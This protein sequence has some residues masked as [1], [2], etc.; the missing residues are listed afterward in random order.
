MEKEY[1]QDILYK[2][3]SKKSLKNKNK[4]GKGE[5]RSIET[6]QEHRKNV[7]SSKIKDELEL[8]E[9]RKGKASIKL[10]DIISN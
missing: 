8:E 9:H 10:K 5:C 3:N 6:K 7:E 1:I 2:Y 4:A